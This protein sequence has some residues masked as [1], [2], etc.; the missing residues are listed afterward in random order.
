MNTNEQIMHSEYKRMF[1]S[2][3]ENNLGQ[4]QNLEGLDNS[5]EGT[6][7]NKAR[8]EL[9][10]TYNAI[11]MK[12]HNGQPLTAAEVMYLGTATNISL[13]NLKKRL[14]YQRLT[15]EMMENNIAPIFKE[16]LTFK[17]DETALVDEFY[18]KVKE[19][20]SKPDETEIAVKK[21]E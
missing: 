16:V 12:I 19:R 6:A 18:L 13:M 3:I 5:T 11:R 4:L 1:D 8:K 14:E 7:K 10:R 20:L 15:I 21:V 9:E 17:E 2:I